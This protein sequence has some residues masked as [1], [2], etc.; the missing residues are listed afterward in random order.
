[1]EGAMSLHEGCD[2]RWQH[3]LAHITA[4]A[5]TTPECTTVEATVLPGDS[6]AYRIAAVAQE[7]A[8]RAFRVRY[9]SS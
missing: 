2:P 7:D 3:Q 1:M 6:F 4:H 9:L 5:H 8:H